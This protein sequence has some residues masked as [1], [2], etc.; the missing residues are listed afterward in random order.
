MVGMKKNEKESFVEI[1]ED[2]MDS[3]SIMHM[4]FH[5]LGRYHE[6][7]RIDRDNYVNIFRENMLEGTVLPRT[8]IAKNMLLFQF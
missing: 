6:H 3:R 8:L 4:L 5:L 1:D 7:Q 2:V